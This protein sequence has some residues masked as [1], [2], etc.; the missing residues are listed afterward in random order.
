MSSGAVE[1]RRSTLP[2]KLAISIAAQGVQSTVQQK[3]WAVSVGNTGKKSSPSRT[4][5]APPTVKSAATNT[6]PIY[7]RVR[8]LSCS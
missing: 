8:T 7:A 5:E 2:T 6:A 3:K 1:P 4:R